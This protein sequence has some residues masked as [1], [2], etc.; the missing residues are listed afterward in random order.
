MEAES[1]L[2]G[3]VIDVDGDGRLMLE[4]REGVIHTIISGDVLLS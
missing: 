2:S 4:D 3:T 1:R